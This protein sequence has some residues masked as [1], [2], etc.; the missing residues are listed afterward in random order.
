MANLQVR[1]SVNNC[2]YWSQNNYCTAN[3]I[4][5][6]SDSTSNN[7]TAGYDAPSVP[8]DLTTPV[9]MSMETC[10]KTF[11]PNNSASRD[12]DNVKRQ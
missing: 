3:N 9:Q 1:C 12:M 2:H 5:V 8:N 6:T 10:C 7:K 11:V 4:L